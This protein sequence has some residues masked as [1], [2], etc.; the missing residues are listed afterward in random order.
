[1]KNHGVPYGLFCW[2]K[3]LTKPHRE[4]CSILREYN[5]DFKIEQHI[6]PYVVDILSGQSVIEIYGNFWH[7]NP[8]RY[9]PNDL[10]PIPKTQGRL[11]KD[12][13]EKD[14]KRID[15]ILQKGYNV[16]ILWE[17]EIFQEQ[18]STKERICKSLKLKV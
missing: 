5:V 11:A 14:K 4:V 16:L 3:S 12:I 17:D 2:Q 13:W 15:Y 6:R 7:A 18:D 1:M 8:N 10:V 9:K